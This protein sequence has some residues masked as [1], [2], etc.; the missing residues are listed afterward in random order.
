MHI[1]TKLN[2]YIFQI[3]CGLNYF[4]SDAT[5]VVLLKNEGDNIFEEEWTQHSK[6]SPVTLRCG[7]SNCDFNIKVYRFPPAHAIGATSPV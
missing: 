4:R 3:F 2:A 6:S 7:W 1:F 5:T